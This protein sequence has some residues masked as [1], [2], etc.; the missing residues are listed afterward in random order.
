MALGPGE[1]GG[2]RVE[3]DARAK[4]PRRRKLDRRLGVRAEVAPM[5]RGVYGQPGILRGIACIEVL[6][7]A[8][9]CCRICDVVLVGAP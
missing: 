6:A 8:M 7:P 2:V 4:F 3:A 5:H 9:A 1:R